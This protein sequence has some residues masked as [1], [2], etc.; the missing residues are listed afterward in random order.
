[1]QP[2]SMVV[3]Y[4]ND[5][6]MCIRRSTWLVYYVG[7]LQT[8]TQ[9]LFIMPN[10]SNPAAARVSLLLG[11]LV[12][13]T[14][15]SAAVSTT[16]AYDADTVFYGNTD[17]SSSVF[18]ADYSN[19]DLIN[20]NLGT[21]IT[22]AWIFA[23]TA[24]TDGLTG[25]LPNLSENADDGAFPNAAATSVVYDLGAGDNLLGYDLTGVTSIAGWGAGGFW[26]QNYTI[27]VQGVGD[28][29]GAWTTLYSVAY[30][31]GD[32]GAGAPSSGGSSR[33]IA[34]DLDD[35]ILA[36]GV[37]YVR[38]TA[39]AGGSVYRELDVFGVSTVPEPSTYALLAGILGLSSVMIRRR[40]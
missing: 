31:V 19:L 22:G 40:K 2:I 21:N 5:G 10:L 12:L 9:T 18:D 33:V 23:P 25:T 28:G 14:S 26:I 29:S 8:I 30:N 7:F 34:S 6:K 1:M 3:L 17:V 11:T 37:Q 32:P 13:A 16:T 24:M 36:S 35:G 15:A 4:I 38:F 20:G 39:D 27:E